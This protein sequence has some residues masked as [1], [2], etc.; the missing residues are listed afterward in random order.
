MAD[1]VIVGAGASGLFTAFRL[2][3]TKAKLGDTVNLYEWS[4]TT[5]EGEPRTQPPVRR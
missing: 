4:P 5:W 2:L 1:Y 3:K